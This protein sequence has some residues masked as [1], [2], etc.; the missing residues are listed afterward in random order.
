[1][2]TWMSP[3]VSRGF[4]GHRAEAAVE[5]S[6]HVPGAVRDLSTVVDPTEKRTDRFLAQTPTMLECPDACA[7]G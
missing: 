6:A 3:G 1:M 7:L 4:G 2:K 5:R